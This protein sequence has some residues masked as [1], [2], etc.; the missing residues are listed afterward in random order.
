M[1]NWVFGQ[2]ERFAAAVAMRPS[3]NLVSEY[4]QHDIVI[5]GSL[6]LGPPPWPDLDELWRRSP[7][8]YVQNIKAPLLLP[9]GE[10]D[11]RGAISQSGE[12]SGAA[13]LPG[14]TAERA[15]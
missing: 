7:T 13:R 3:S 9:C 2:T 1:T 4:A 11:R 12:T 10:M 14:K 15:R 8:K 6:E 5:W